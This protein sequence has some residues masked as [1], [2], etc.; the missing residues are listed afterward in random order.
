MTE[1]QALPTVKVEIGGKEYIL[2]YSIYAFAKLKKVAKINALKGEVDY[3]DPDHLLYFLWA[4]LISEQPELDGELVDGKPDKNLETALRQL[5]T[6]LTIVKLNKIAD[7]VK[8]AFNSAIGLSDEKKGGDG[9][10]AHEKK[11]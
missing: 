2:H 10:P 6:A 9:A 3:Q 5:G 8:S 4:G 11:R 7:L 1:N